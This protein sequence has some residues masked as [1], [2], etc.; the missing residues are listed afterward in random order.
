MEAMLPLRLHGAG[1]PGELVCADVVD[2]ARPQR[3]L[4]RPRTHLHL[5]AIEDAVRAE[6]AQVLVPIAF[7]GECRHFV[8]EPAEHVDGEAPDAAGGAVDEHRPRVGALAVELHRVHGERG[9]EPRGADRH[10]VAERHCAGQRDQPVPGRAYVLGVAAV[11]VLA[12]TEAGDHHRIAL[13]VAVIAGGV[14]DTGHV[15]SPDHGEPAHD[16]TRPGRGQRV[17]V[18]DAGPRGADDDVAFVQIVEGDVLEAPPGLP[19]FLVYAVCEKR[20]HGPSPS[21]RA[22]RRVATVANPMRT[23]ILY[24]RPGPGPDPGEG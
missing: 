11:G 15:D 17:L 14:H 19:L 3:S 18:V 9:G 2:R 24:Y 1:Q 10:A 7:S 5:V 6:P 12:Q 8:A 20:L 13:G 21:A 23:R 4:Q 22:G 16:P